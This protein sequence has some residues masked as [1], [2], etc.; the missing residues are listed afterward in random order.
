MYTYF[1]VA[2]WMQRSGYVHI[3]YR[4]CMDAEERLFTG[5]RKL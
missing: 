1:T 3:L 2:A 4:G 5:L